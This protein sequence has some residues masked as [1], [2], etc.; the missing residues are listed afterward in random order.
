MFGADRNVYSQPGEW[1]ISLS[2]RNLVSNRHYNGT[3]EQVHRQE[4]ENYVTNR[5]NLAD[6]TLSRTLTERLSVTVGIPYVNS[7]WARRDPRFPLPAA[8]REIQQDG[9]GLGDISVA[10]RYWIFDPGTHVD[11]N[12]AAGLGVKTPT[13]NANAQ[14][15]LPNRAGF[16]PALRSVD[17]SV[18]PGDGGWGILL[19]AQAF[20]IV[21]RVMLFASGS[22]LANPRDANDTPS[23]LATLDIP[24]TGDREGLGVNSV[25]DQYLARVGGSV[26]LW[27][28][29]GASLA[30]RMEGLRRYDLIGGSH[31]WR[32]PGTAMFIEPGASYSTGQHTVSL[33]IPIGYYYNRHVNPYTGDD[34]DATF[35]RHI[36]LTSYSVRLGG[37]G[38]RVTD[39]PPPASSVNR[40]TP[41][42]P[43]APPLPA[44]SAARATTETGR[45]QALDAG[46]HVSTSTKVV[47]PIDV[48]C[49]P[50]TFW[51]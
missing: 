6:L 50:L 7:S 35:P 24:L 47:T 37:G 10:G 43:T 14:D 1:Q 31:G 11:W 42:H 8:R 36:F 20:W 45:A 18:Q 25:P 17:Q 29:F 32:R 27:K 2:S 4:L 12:V 13:G 3:V 51:Q 48:V 28:G 44:P 38:A 21:D 46:R 49:L 5:Q 40:G 41:A 34:G 33:N 16:D 9:R 15:L 22:Y 39:Q 26:A 30:W 23:I 19:D